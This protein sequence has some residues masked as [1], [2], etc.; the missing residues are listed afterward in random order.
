MRTKWCHI[1]RTRRYG[2]KTLL[3]TDIKM[4]YCIV[5]NWLYYVI[6]TIMSTAGLA[7][8]ITGRHQSALGCQVADSSAEATKSI[9]FAHNSQVQTH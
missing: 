9:A 2:G 3:E 7:A 8:P 1:G 6:S 5:L 4:Y